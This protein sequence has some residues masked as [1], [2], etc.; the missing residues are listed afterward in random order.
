M[1]GCLFNP[2]RI[3]GNTGAH[4]K[5]ALRIQKMSDR[6]WFEERRGK[7]DLKAQESALREIKTRQGNRGVGA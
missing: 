6:C 1:A 7:V 2:M 3:N 4:I 5:G